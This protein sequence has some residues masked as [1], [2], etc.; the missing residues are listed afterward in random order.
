MGNIT[1]WT[2]GYA[3]DDELL[4]TGEGV[5]LTPANFSSIQLQS[6]TPN[7]D[8]LCIGLRYL[9]T[10]E[11]FEVIRVDCED[12]NLSTLCV[13]APEITFNCSAGQENN[14]TAVGGGEENEGGR[15]RS[16]VLDNMLNPEIKKK[17]KKS[18]VQIKKSYRWEWRHF[19]RCSISRRHY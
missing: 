2:F 16:N 10:T 3:I 5:E 4:V 18:L 11:K 13:N 14:I 7:P 17:Q 8:N 15:S 12:E 9:D 6:T 19:V 1:F